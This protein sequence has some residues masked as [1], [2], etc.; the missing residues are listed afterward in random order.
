MVFGA[1][2]RCYALKSSLLEEYLAAG[3]CLGSLFKGSLIVIGDSGSSLARPYTLSLASGAAATGARIFFKHGIPLPY[4]C[5]ATKWLKA[6]ATVYLNLPPRESTPQ[7]IVLRS[8]ERPIKVPNRKISLNWKV[9][10]S[11]QELP[12]LSS[13]YLSKLL[14]VAGSTSNPAMVT[15][16][17]Y[18]E[19]LPL[20]PMALSRLGFNV[21]TIM[22][23]VESPLDECENRVREVMEASR[24]TLGLLLDPSATEIR[25]LDQH[26]TPVPSSTRVSIVLRALLRRGFRRFLIPSS[27]KQLSTRVKALGGSIT[28]YPRGT[29]P[30]KPWKEV[31]AMVTV[32]CHVILR[33][34]PWIDPILEGLLIASEASSGNP[35]NNLKNP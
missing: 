24:S 16:A 22:F 28:E 5:F 14:E 10:E 29:P 26:G 15:T 31:D 20:L 27:L 3:Y 18:R 7:I 13:S 33:K 2:E 17:V 8:G 23:F 19:C 21:T 35:P 12:D 32:D 34:L 9:A 6:K 4:A 11:F 25:I 1:S 30:R